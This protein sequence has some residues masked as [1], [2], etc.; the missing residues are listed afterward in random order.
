MRKLFPGQVV[1]SQGCCA[2]G[3]YQ[4]S[5]PGFDQHLC[6]GK[7]VEDFAIADFAAQ[8]PGGAL[9]IAILPW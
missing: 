9:I 1:G 6:L 3:P 7:T 4:V 5:T 2:D 8:R